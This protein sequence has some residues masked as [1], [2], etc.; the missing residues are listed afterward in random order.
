[1]GTLVQD[2]AG[3]LTGDLEYPPKNKGVRGFSPQK[4]LTFKHCFNTILN[5][6][7][8]SEKFASLSINCRK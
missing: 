2:D 6:K 1:M 5:M 7:I 8:V 4:I 3:A